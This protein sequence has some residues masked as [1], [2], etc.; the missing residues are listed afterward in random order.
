M[1]FLATIVL[2]AATLGSVGTDAIADC[3]AA[4]A[5]DHAAHIDCLENA[6]RARGA[7]SVAAP[8]TGVPVVAAPSAV[9]TTMTAAAVAP[10]VPAQSAPPGN[11][12]TGLGAEQ[13]QARQ[14]P[15]D[16]PAEQVEVRIVSAGYNAAG[17]G[18]FRMADGQVWRETVA[19]PDRHHLDSDREYAA[20]IERSKIGGYRMYVEGVRWMHK[21]ER[22]Q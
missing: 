15:L 8:A 5:G 17:L 2:T 3:R 18:I 14:K 6:L 1:S 10:A 11:Q 21:V 20:R 22:L 7:A 9:A 16:A 13:A 12:P 19:T 4:H